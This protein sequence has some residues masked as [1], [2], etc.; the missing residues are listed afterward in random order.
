[1]NSVWNTWVASG[2]TPLS[3]TAPV[4]LAKADWKIE[5]VVTAAA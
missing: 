5:T 4:V 1:M 2:H 3:T